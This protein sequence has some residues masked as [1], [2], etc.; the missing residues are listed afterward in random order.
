MGHAT[1]DTMDE[2]VTERD[3]I[4][5]QQEERER[6]EPRW[7]AFLEWFFALFMGLAT[8]LFGLLPILPDLSPVSTLGGIALVSSVLAW[9]WHDRT[10]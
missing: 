5:R 8:V 10:D 2:R 7:R 6:Q 3:C 9:C 1:P 4:E